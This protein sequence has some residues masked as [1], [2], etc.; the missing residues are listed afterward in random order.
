[1]YRSIG[2]GGSGLRLG[3]PDRGQNRRLFGP[4]SR[5]EV[6]PRWV[7]PLRASSVF[8]ELSMVGGFVFDSVFLTPSYTAFEAA[9]FFVGTDFFVGADFVA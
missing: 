3:I 5:S 7:R 6:L 1:M 9:D 8:V 2:I 4:I